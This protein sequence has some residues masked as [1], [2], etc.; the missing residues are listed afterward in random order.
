MSEKSERL[1]YFVL[2]KYGQSIQFYPN[3][4]HHHAKYESFMCIWRC[5]S[6]LCKTKYFPPTKHE[7]IHTHTLHC[8]DAIM[9]IRSN[10]H[11]RT[12]T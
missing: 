3:K 11:E 6:P 2:S 1:Y 8:I 4:T 10:D 5:N 9:L 12:M 7:Y